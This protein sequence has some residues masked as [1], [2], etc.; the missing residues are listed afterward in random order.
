MELLLQLAALSPTFRT[1]DSQ[2]FFELL[3]R[4]LRRS[5]NASGKVIDK[6]MTNIFQF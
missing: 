1:A 6:L 4:P 2:Y 3:S 5:C